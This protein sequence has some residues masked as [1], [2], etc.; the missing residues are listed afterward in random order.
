M[1]IHP[2]IF[3]GNL[4]QLEKEIEFVDR[5]YGNI[6]IDIE[7]GNYIDN[8]TFGKKILKDIC[9]KSNSYKTVHLMVNHPES[10]VDVLAE[11]NIDLVF[12]HIDHLRYPSEII[13]KFLMKGIKVGVALNPNAEISE[14]FYIAEV[15]ELLLMM[16]EPDMFGQLFI[17]NLTKKITRYISA[18]YSVWCDGGIHFDKLEDLESLG[19]KNVVM[20]RAVFEKR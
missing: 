12:I 6:H 13:N 3:S 7:D 9:E 16:C 15:E 19:V 20:G 17:P 10:F 4:L 5:Q 1:R 11:C 8:I 2:S 14:E 18:G